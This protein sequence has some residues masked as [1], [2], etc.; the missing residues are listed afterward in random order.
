MTRTRNVLQAF[1]VAG[2][3]SALGISV[4][5]L[6]AS[7]IIHD[8]GI[9]VNEKG[10][11]WCTRANDA[12]AWTD[13][14]FTAPVTGS[15]NEPVKGCICVDNEADNDLLN[16]W[17][18]MGGP[19]PAHADFNDYD[20]LRDKILLDAR[21]QCEEEADNIGPS[22]NCQD[23]LTDANLLFYDGRSDKCRV[24][25][26]YADTDTDGRPPDP[27]PFDLTT[28]TCSAGVCTASQ[29]L[30]DDMLTR[31][32]AFLLDSTRVV[33][34]TSG[35]Y[36]QDVERGD[37]AYIVG[38]RSDDKLIS[39]DGNPVNDLADISD[40]LKDLAN[41]TS[42]TAKLKDSYG[43]NVTIQISIL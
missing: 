19:P 11:S 39:I 7:C 6:G 27:N 3:I 17:V 36:F 18:A 29:G 16:A 20:L 38:I 13:P 30:I 8:T 42:A 2:C 33:V 28:L 1:G 5:A 32:S 35:I 23:V 21:E 15:D 37:A 31:P 34:K 10:Y 22:N 12:Q 14:D 40:A 9:V 41:S 43:A 4:L 26:L 25:A 24:E